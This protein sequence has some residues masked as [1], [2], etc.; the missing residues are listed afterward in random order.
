M[1]YDPISRRMFL[2][3]M[4]GALLSIPMLPSMLIKQAFAADDTPIKFV[5]FVSRYGQMVQNWKPLL[6]AD[7]IVAAN[8]R[9]KPLSE[10]PNGNINKII[11]STTFSG[12]ST[13]KLTLIEGLDLPNGGG[14]N[15]CASTTAGGMITGE[16]SPPIFPYSIDHIL[17]TSPKIYSGS[18]PIRAL[19]LVPAKEATSESI[20]WN[21]IAGLP[22]TIPGYWDEK[23][24]FD[25]L[26]ANKATTPAGI[27]AKSLAIDQVLGDLNAVQNGGRIGA[28]DK[29]VLQNYADLIRD[30]QTRIN[31][32]ATVTT[33]ATPNLIDPQ[34]INERMY[35]NHIDLLVAAMACGMTKVGSIYCRN[36]SPLF[37]ENG[38]DF[39]GN[40][41]DPDT[42]TG[43]ETSRVY[44]TWIAARF[45]ELLRKM[46][47]IIEPNGKSLLNNSICLWTNEIS[48][49]LH[50]TNIN[51][52]VLIGGSANG[53]LDAGNYFDFRTYPYTYYAG[54]T[55]FKEQGRLYN[56]LMISILMAMGLTPADWERDGLVGFGEYGR[57]YYEIGQYDT[58]R[59]SRR[60]P[61][62]MFYKG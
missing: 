42:A 8:L 50:H 6:P 30:V 54:R 35:S 47:A 46:D 2:Q 27:Q 61:L 49:G 39:H 12:I 15:V 24:V 17:E 52:P 22:Q 48:F 34:Q 45:A 19:R 59:L 1:K 51:M 41:H 31:Q 56:E 13:S 43:Q 14:H 40:S 4:G 9:W 3:G 11:N 44:N 57:A 37:N 55:D 58:Y 18:V 62:P 33:C 25:L 60:S 38:S 20:W 23:V 16:G 21:R 5:Q 10:Y 28:A 7:R 53:K 36:F 29:A 32:A 26:F